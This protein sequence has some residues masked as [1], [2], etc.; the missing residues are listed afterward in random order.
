MQVFQF[1][2]TNLANAFVVAV[3]CLITAECFEKRSYYWLRVALS[4][5]II[6]VWMLVTREIETSFFNGQVLLTGTVRF[7]VMFLMYGLSVAFW[8]KASFCQALF[9]IT[10]SY[11]LQNLCERLA[12]VP[13]FF[14]RCIFQH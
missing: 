9:A 14:F 6:S 4:V 8:C 7:A 13:R 1:L 10:V 5:L 2:L 11:S 3:G 12:E